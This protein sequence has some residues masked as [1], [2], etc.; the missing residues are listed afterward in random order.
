MAAANLGPD[1]LDL[2]NLAVSAQRA[3]KAPQ[4]AWA[5]RPY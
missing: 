2:S 3:R 4:D 5:H 1:C